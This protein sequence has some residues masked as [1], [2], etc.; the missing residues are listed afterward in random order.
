M[1]LSAAQR[2]YIRR[3]TRR[4]EAS[5]LDDELNIV[6]FLDI[7]MN[8]VMVLLAISAAAMAN[9]TVHAQLPTYGSAGTA[10]SFRP[11][12][13]LTSGGTVVAD[14]EGTYALGCDARARG[15][16]LPLVG[17]EHDMLAL[18]T[19]AE[20]LKSAHPDAETVH[21]SADARVPL[22]TVILAMDAL[23][24]GGDPLFPDVKITAGVR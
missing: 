10:P 18:R 6:P 21:L 3:R 2:A 8:L 4:A 14:A 7:V 5:R 12:V 22:Q 24:G 1:K 16:T 20:R 23:R 17:G 9:R 19:C 15:V 13:V 11:T